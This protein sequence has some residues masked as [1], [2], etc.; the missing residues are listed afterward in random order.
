MLKR[1]MDEMPPSVALAIVLLVLILSTLFEPSLAPSNYPA[2]ASAHNESTDHQ[3][4]EI[5]SAVGAVAAAI[6]TGVL[7][8]FAFI[9][10]R[11]SR[12]S[13]ERQLRAY[14]HI[15]MANVVYDGGFL[16]AQVE[17]F[18]SGSTPAYGLTHWTTTGSGIKTDFPEG[19]KTGSR[20]DLAPHVPMTT[21]TPFKLS[22]G[23]LIEVITG[24][25]QIY[26]WGE[27]NYTDA[28]GV[29][30]WTKYRLTHTG[31]FPKDGEVVLAPCP[32]GNRSI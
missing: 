16:I 18:N 17:I 10:V 3:F 1:W 15:K 8:A 31:P 13:S 28:F 24:K 2:Y 27:I 5:L 23:A 30:R 21:R 11:D 6:F 7:A 29:D 12:R 4:W 20:N 22:E 26:V 25:R 9:Q 32:D 19:D 14:V